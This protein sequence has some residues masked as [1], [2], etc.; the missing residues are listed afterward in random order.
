MTPTDDEVIARLRASLKATADRTPISAGRSTASAAV[1]EQAPSR[2]LMPAL[3]A[4]AAVA[5]VVAVGVVVANSHPVVT[6]P[7]NQVPAGRARASRRARRPPATTPSK[8]TRRSPSSVAPQAKPRRLR[9]GELLRD[10]LAGRSGR[11]HLHAACDAGRLRALRRVGH[12]LAQPLCGQRHVVRRVRPGGGHPRLR[13]GCLPAD[14]H[15][16]RRRF[17]EWRFRQCAPGRLDT[18]HGERHR[19]RTCSTR[20][21]ATPSSDGRRAAQRSPSA[22]QATLRRSSTSPTR[23][24]C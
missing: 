5:A 8:P 12:D 24:F 6:A 9:A 20:G 19:G 7:C 22:A 4:A 11:S 16:G 14:G 15:Q 3:S 21:T 2:G 17:G 18:D 23:W 10:R 1:A 13:Y